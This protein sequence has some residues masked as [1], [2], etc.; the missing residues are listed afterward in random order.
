MNLYLLLLSLGAV[1]LLQTT[2][3]PALAIGGVT[4]DLMLILVAGWA[5]LWDTP[6]ATAWAIIGGLWLDVLSGSPFGFYTAG[7]IVGALVASLG[8]RL[9]HSG[10]LLL[11][12]A[13]VAAGTLTRSLLQVAILTLTG[14]SLLPLD[15]LVRLTSLEIVANVVLMALIF[16]LLSALGRALGRERLSLE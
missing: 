16:P 3:L 11:P 13:L 7:L 2:F 12:M 8:A 5:L 4:P 9:F 14:H 15:I 6:S 1:A 10:N